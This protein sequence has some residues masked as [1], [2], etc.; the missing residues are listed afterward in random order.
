M[1]EKKVAAPTYV[2]I[3]GEEYETTE[4]AAG[5]K[6]YVLRE[7]SVK[8]NDD[9]E[10]ASQNPDKTFNGR[11]NLRLCLAASIVSPKTTVDDIGKWPGK[12]YLTLSRAFN[13]VNSLSEG[14]EGNA[15]GQNV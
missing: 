1:A 4:V 14:A 7:L 5:S 13:R 10:D 11:L 3:D 6:T 15:S 9:I 8:E 2:T 12:C